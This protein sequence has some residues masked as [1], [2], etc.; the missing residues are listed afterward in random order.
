MFFPAIENVFDSR[1]FFEDGLG[2]VRV[3]PKIRLRREL[4]Q[5]FDP[6][7]LAVNVKAASAKA[8][9]ALPGG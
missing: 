2:P 3:V 9:A 8:R 6:F 1:L 7:L 4:I 5:L